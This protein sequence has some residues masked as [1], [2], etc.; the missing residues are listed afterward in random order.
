MESGQASA[1]AT[2][3]TWRLA[4]SCFGRERRSVEGTGSEWFGGC[5]RGWAAPF[6]L[7]TQDGS[8][9]VTNSGHVRR[10]QLFSA[11]SIG[12]HSVLDFK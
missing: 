5:G 12:L 4:I 6:R 3:S 1:C 2:E 10:K 7:S 11:P 8:T 9:F